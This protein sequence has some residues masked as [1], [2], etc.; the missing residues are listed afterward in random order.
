MKITEKTKLTNAIE[1]LAGDTYTED[2]HCVQ[3]LA[4]VLTKKLS[5]RDIMDLKMLI[6]R[7]TQA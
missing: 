3:R 6:E 7:K 4:E 1:M 2:S 5:L